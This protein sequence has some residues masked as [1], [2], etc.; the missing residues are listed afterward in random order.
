MQR[1]GELADRGGV[2]STALTPL[3]VRD[4]PAAQS[5]SFGQFLLGQPGSFSVPLEQHSER[6]DLRRFRHGTCRPA[7]AR[8]RGKSRRAATRLTGRGPRYPRAGDAEG[9]ARGRWIAAMTVPPFATRSTI[10]ASAR[11]VPANSVAGAAAIEEGAEALASTAGISGR[12][13]GNGGYGAL[14]AVI[15]PSWT[16]AWTS[17]T[18][19]DPSV[20]GNRA[21]R[22]AS[23]SVQVTRPP[24]ATGG[25]I[26]STRY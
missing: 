24:T 18:M 13:N 21:L 3:Q 17:S 10:S 20:S 9:Y 2:R 4:A 25:L 1:F 22:R 12:R 15:L 6:P 14:S 11:V 23:R 19:L 8:R 7:Y 5:G 26:V 16:S